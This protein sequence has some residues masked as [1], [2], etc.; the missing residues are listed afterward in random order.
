[1]TN[2]CKPCV[3]LR[4][5]SP[6]LTD[7]TVL[8]QP[9]KIDSIMSCLLMGEEYRNTHTLKLLSGKK[10]PCKPR[11]IMARQVKDLFRRFL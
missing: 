4:L 2:Y 3:L 7:T 11:E 6:L 8:S 9:R 10:E 1:M 5:Q